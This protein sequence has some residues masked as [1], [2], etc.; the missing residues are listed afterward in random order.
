M[1]GRIDWT[2]T[3][4]TGNDTLRVWIENFAC[5]GNPIIDCPLR[6]DQTSTSC[7]SAELPLKQGAAG[8]IGA[9]DRGGR[10]PQQM[11]PDLWDYH[12][13]VRTTTPVSIGDADPQLVIV[14]DGLTRFLDSV[15][16]ILRSVKRGLHL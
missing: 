2:F 7:S 8:T 5:D 1:G 9:S 14:R 4:D 11:G 6:F 12:I 3:N 10:C 15:K 16:F 13:M